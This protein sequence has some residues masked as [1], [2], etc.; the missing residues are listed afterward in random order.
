MNNEYVIEKLT[1]AMDA[2]TTGRGDVRS[3][4]KNAYSL[5]HAYFTES[6]HPFHVKAAT[7]N[8]AKLPPPGA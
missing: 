6:C 7:R 4:I 3:R 2:L 1:D 5:M 8:A